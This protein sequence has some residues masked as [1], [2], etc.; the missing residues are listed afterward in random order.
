[1]FVYRHIYPKYACSCCKDGVTSAEPAA[2][3][4]E[5]GLAG[6]GLLGSGDTVWNYRPGCSATGIVSCNTRRE[7]SMVSPEPREFSMVSPEP[8]E[9]SM[10]SPE[11]RGTLERSGLRGVRRRRCAV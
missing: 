1:V 8:R 5:G 4:I 2:S 11:P 10:V 6:P 7:F 9:F 3:P